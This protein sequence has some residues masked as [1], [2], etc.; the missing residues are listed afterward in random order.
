[1]GLDDWFRHC[2]TS[3]TSAQFSCNVLF[4]DAAARR[5]TVPTVPAPAAADPPAPPS[6]SRSRHVCRPLLCSAREQSLGRVYVCM[7]AR[8]RLRV[9]RTAGCAAACHVAAQPIA[10]YRLGRLTPQILKMSSLPRGPRVRL[11]WP[12]P[13]SL[14]STP[15]AAVLH[16]GCWA[17]GCRPALETGLAAACGARH[18]SRDTK[19]ATRNPRWYTPPT[20]DT[21]A[22][23]TPPTSAAPGADGAAHQS[24]AI[25]PPRRGGARVAGGGGGPGGGRP[26]APGRGRGPRRP[27]PRPW[28]R[29]CRPAGPGTA[30]PS[31]AAGTRPP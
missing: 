17:A 22:T 27:R 2:D 9:R 24:F 14:S 25:T 7:R 13:T 31:S 30:W 12:Q 26:G 6:L 4:L 1:M 5:P 20:S 16:N 8:A 29:R 28:A 23:P 21:Q 3:A 19:A 10:M 15:L 11:L 18:G